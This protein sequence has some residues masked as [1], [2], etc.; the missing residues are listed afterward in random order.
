[1]RTEQTPNAEQ[2]EERESY[3]IEVWIIQNGG[4]DKITSHTM[5]REEAQNQVDRLRSKSEEFA[6]FEEESG[7]EVTYKF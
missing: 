1:M 5:D 7:E 2:T 4:V 6:V 3:F